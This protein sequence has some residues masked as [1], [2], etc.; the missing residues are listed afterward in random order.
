MD[1]KRISRHL[2]IGG[3]HVRR[4]FPEETLGRITAAIA[5]SEGG[6]HGEIRF[7]V[8]ASLDW[9]ALA[10]GVTARERAVQVFSELRVWDTEANNGVLIY[11]LVADRDVEILADRGVH[12]KVGAEG[13]ETI[14]KRMEAE[15]R[16]GRFESGVI[17]GIQAVG[18]HLDAH[19]PRS[20]PD[21]NELPDR[22]VLL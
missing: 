16:Q 8:E 5:S 3:P 17:Q 18:R 22:P 1:W 19:F 13:W 11:L 9:R 20:G 10:R 6:H 2:W 7:A 21:V 12:A 4:L 14:C 15:F